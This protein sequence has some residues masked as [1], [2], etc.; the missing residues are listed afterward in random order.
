MQKKLISIALFCITNNVSIE[1][2]PHC[3]HVKDLQTWDILLQ[4]GTKDGVY[5][6]PVA[7]SS[8][9]PILAFFAVK[10]TMSI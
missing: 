1:L 8:T 6:W 7:N 10:T 4:G 5:E 3:F 2:F 9:S